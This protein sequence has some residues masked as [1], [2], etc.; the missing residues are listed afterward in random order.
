MIL[1]KINVLKP[2]HFKNLNE[3]IQNLLPYYYKGV[4]FDFSSSIEEDSQRSNGL[5]KI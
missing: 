5:K 4:R 3:S 1:I 2:D